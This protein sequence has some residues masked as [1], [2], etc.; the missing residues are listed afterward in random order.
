MEIGA[1][2]DA[3]V[4]LVRDVV[5]QVPDALAAVRREAGEEGTRHPVLDRLQD[6]VAAQASFCLARLTGD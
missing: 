6:E 3:A 5:E 4:A 1:R 2:P